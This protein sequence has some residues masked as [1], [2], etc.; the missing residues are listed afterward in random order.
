[1]GTLHEYLYAFII[2]FRRIL[3]RMRNISDRSCRKNR[4]T[5]FMSNNFFFFRKSCRLW[6][7]AEKCG[8]ARQATDE[9]LIRRMRFA[10]WITKSADAHSEYKM[11]IAFQ[12]QKW[13][14]ERASMLR[15]QV[16]CLSCL[17]FF[18][19][20]LCY[21][22]EPSEMLISIFFVISMLNQ[23]FFNGA[24]G[25]SGPGPPHCRGFTI[26]LRHTTLRRTPL[27]EWSAR[28]RDL[29][30]TTHNT[31]KRQT[32]I[33]PG[34]FEPTIPAS[35]RP[36]THALDRAATGIGELNQVRSLISILRTE[37]FFSYKSLSN[38]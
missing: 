20:V 38:S 9:N 36:Q 26:T 6:D 10:C 13:L 31:H 32:S 24:T 23:V 27:D 29:Y 16:H 28:C 33:P 5:N 21:L 1:M 25:S 8:R 17:I 18:W 3:L 7:S 35:E 2:M 34:G 14:R 15:L 22:T 4:N 30:L 12:R 37:T 11:R 19:L